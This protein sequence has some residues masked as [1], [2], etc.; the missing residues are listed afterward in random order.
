MEKWSDPTHKNGEHTTD[1]AERGSART[2]RK[3]ISSTAT[4]AWN[5]NKDRSTQRL[6]STPLPTDRQSTAII[7]SLTTGVQF[8]VTAPAELPMRLE[9]RAEQQEPAIIDFLTTGVRFPVTAPAELPMRLEKRDELQ[10][11]L[12]AL[13]KQ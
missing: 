7:D 4:P 3:P 11:L 5:D 10:E 8:P 12:T 9:K 2:V 6:L 13:K 1:N